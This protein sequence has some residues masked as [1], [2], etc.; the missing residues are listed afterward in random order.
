MLNN[1]WVAECDSALYSVDYNNYTCIRND[2]YNAILV[3]GNPQ[4]QTSS[5]YSR[6]NLS[7]TIKLS[8]VTSNIMQI[9]GGILSMEIINKRGSITMNQ[10]TQI[11]PTPDSNIVL[12]NVLPL[13]TGATNQYLNNTQVVELNAATI[14]NYVEGTIFKVKAEVQNSWGDV[15]IDYITFLKSTTPT[16]GDATIT[17]TSTPWKVQESMT[18]ALTGSWYSSQVNIMELWIKLDLKLTNG[19]IITLA[20][21]KWEC[22]LFTF[23]LPII[24]QTSNSAIPTSLLITATNPSEKS[25]VL[26][27][28]LTINN[29]ISSDY[30]ST[31]FSNHLHYTDI[32]NIA[33]ASSQM[34]SLLVTPTNFIYSQNAC[35]DNVDWS[36]QGSWVMKRN[37]YFWEWNEGYSGVDCSLESHEY[38]VLKEIVYKS[39]DTLTKNMTSSG[40]NSRTD[41]ESN[42]ILLSNLWIRPEFISYEYIG[43]ISQII[44]SISNMNDDPL[45]SWSDT[46]ISSFI[47]LVSL[48][49]VR[50]EY[51]YNV[52]LKLGNATSYGISISS[53]GYT[54][55]LAT[56][57]KNSQLVWIALE[58]FLTKISART[59]LSN[60]LATYETITGQFKIEYKI[61]N[62]I[63]GTSYTINNSKNYFIQFPSNLFDSTSITDM[64]SGIRIISV[65][66]Y[67]NPY[68][69]SE[70]DLYKYESNTISVYLLGSTRNIIKI[71]SKA[72]SL[73]IPFVRFYNNAASNELCTSWD[74]NLSNNTLTD[75]VWTVSISDTSSNIFSEWY[76]CKH[77]SIATI[78]TSHL[79]SFALIA[80]SNNSIISSQIIGYGSKRSESEDVPALYNSIGLLFMLCVFALFIF[81]TS[82]FLLFDFKLISAFFCK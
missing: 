48:F 56:L 10:F 17:W 13:I 57:Q 72:L 34:K 35:N 21:E 24:S 63:N 70:L 61:A 52:K 71:D 8:G 29:T 5:L 67:I 68:P 9:A 20:V 45:L 78:T 77:K 49:Y 16:I 11:E 23:T 80:P 18:V 76:S 32:N 79:S 59:T 27:K 42:L 82:I 2:Y 81:G 30:A 7:T 46:F 43:I 28:S 66:W 14:D 33:F 69:V 40:L 55:K 74:I 37:G 75:S 50:I 12:T 58:K 3:N 22:K 38:S 51:E 53:A 54:S 44:Q 31:A 25:A 6:D 64:Q 4:W 39:I 36:N 1:I 73:T 60:P 15:S 19:N 65:S 41:F 47:N 62:A 26:V